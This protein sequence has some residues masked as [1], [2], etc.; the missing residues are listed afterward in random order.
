MGYLGVL[1]QPLAQPGPQS[2]Q[3][4]CSRAGGV[5]VQCWEV[6]DTGLEKGAI[7]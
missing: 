4:H 3:D 2:P 7:Y 1:L 6:L 5:A